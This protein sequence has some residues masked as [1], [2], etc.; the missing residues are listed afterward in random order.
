MEEIIFP[1]K[2]RILR[3]MAGKSMQ[4]LAD[5]LGVSL[6]AISKIEKGYRKIDQDQMRAVADFLGTSMTDLFISE[7]DSDDEVLS[8][9]KREIERRVELNR[10]N[11]LKVFGAG[12]RL[13]RGKKDMTLMDVAEKAGLTLSVYHRIE[14][15]QRE[16]YESELFNIAR[17]LGLDVKE[18][19]E[20]IYEMKSD[21][22]LDRAVAQD[23]NPI[24]SMAKI[25]DVLKTTESVWTPSG[26]V[27][28]QKVLVYSKTLPNGNMLVEKPSEDYAVY[29]MSDKKEGIYAVELSSRR[30]GAN[31]PMRS[32]LFID[33]NQ[34][35]RSGD[36]AAQT[37]RDSGSKMEVRLMSVREDMDGKF[38]G[39]Q[40]DPEEK[41]PLSQKEVANLHRIILVS[42]N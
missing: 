11:G 32:I 41:I 39:I 23:N 17:A 2:I 33:P 22:T 26:V 5:T 28:F 15:G 25:S 14:I 40:H 6:S 36:M 29:P 1:N 27:K 8:Q 38:F 19:F 7:D 13:L 21:G 20:K 37:V 42:M 4:D 3:K 30:L 12:L 16:I 34:A 35:V 18:I 31:I 24:D 10:N 9:W